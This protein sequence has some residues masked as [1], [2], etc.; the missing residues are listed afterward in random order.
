MMIINRTFKQ[1]RLLIR[2]LNYEHDLG[3]GDGNGNDNAKLMHAGNYPIAI[4]AEGDKTQV[5][6]GTGHANEPANELAFRAWDKLCGLLRP[7]E[8]QP[9]PPAAAVVELVYIGTLQEAYDYITNLKGLPNGVLPTDFSE[10]YKGRRLRL[11]AMRPMTGNEMIEA[12][13]TDVF[14]RRSYE[15][16]YIDLAQLAQN[17][18]ATRTRV[19]ITALTEDCKDYAAFLSKKMIGEKVAFFAGEALETAVTGQAQSTAVSP[20]AADGERGGV[21]L[22]YQEQKIKQVYDAIVTEGELHPTDERIA[23]KLPIGQ[24][25][26]PYARETVNRYRRK[27]RKRGIKV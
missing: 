9:D 14:A 5:V 26:T 12:E 1:T 21:E 7:F 15:V 8:Y 20:T 16:G 13:I 22:S 11:T 6:F 17:K 24:K 4:L 19:T 25:G 27:M 2:E 3:L 10:L 23:A 18:E